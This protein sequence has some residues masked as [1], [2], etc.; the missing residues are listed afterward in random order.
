[1]KREEK[2]Y[3]FRY[4]GSEL[5]GAKNVSE[6]R[7]FI[8]PKGDRTPEEEPGYPLSTRPGAPTQAHT[9]EMEWERHTNGVCMHTY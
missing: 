5:E 2:K 9:D 7:V 4:E 8:T 1:M 3:N 6:I